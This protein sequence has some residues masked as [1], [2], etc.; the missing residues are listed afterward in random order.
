ME[1]IPKN[2][3]ITRQLR[4]FGLLSSVKLSV[5]SGTLT[6]KQG[7]IPGDSE[8]AIRAGLRKRSSIVLVGKEHLSPFIALRAEANN[9][10][11][12]MGQSVPMIS[13][14]YFVLNKYIPEITDKLNNDIAPRFGALVD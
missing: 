5:W 10:L 14:T 13:G 2:I 4:E 8:E 11:K 1:V 3:N 6:P 9:Y 12:K 7:E